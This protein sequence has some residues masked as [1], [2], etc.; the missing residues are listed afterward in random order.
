M[1]NERVVGRSLAYLKSQNALFE[2]LR[3]AQWLK[4]E[5]EMVLVFHQNDLRVVSARLIAPDSRLVEFGPRDTACAPQPTA[6]CGGL[7]RRVQGGQRYDQGLFFTCAIAGSGRG[8][9]GHAG[10]S[11][12]CSWGTTAAR[13]AHS[14]S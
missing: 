11:L 9:F 5:R 8:A 6:T 4:N 13:A 12:Q 14:G 2:A 7:D 10:T 1:I 3:W